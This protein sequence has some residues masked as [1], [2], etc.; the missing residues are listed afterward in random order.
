M[1]YVDSIFSLYFYVISHLLFGYY[2]FIRMYDK[3]NVI[4]FLVCFYVQYVH[5]FF[6]TKMRQ[7]FI[8]NTK[9][10]SNTSFLLQTYSKIN[11]VNFMRKICET[12]TQ[13]N[14]GSHYYEYTTV[15]V[16]IT[17]AFTHI[18]SIYCHFVRL[19]STADTVVSE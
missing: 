12:I 5:L 15:I 1:Y 6:K 2:I 9:I 3:I 10:Q 14:R 17:Y 7:F 18:L 8:C 4:F 13:V 11:W 19:E 16:I